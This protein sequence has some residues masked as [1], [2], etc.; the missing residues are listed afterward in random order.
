MDESIYEINI[1]EANKYDPLVGEIEV[2]KLN[3]GDIK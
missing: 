2:N 3:K 1:N